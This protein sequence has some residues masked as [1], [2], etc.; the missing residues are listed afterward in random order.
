MLGLVP[1]NNSLL[2]LF[3]KHKALEV[4]LVKLNV[5]FYSKIKI[6]VWAN[7]SNPSVIQVLV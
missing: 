7:R 1:L 6:G 2:R 3:Q 4:L 5:E